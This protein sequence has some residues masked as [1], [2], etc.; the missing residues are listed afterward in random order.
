MTDSTGIVFTFAR[1]CNCLRASLLSL[2]PHLR[3]V[4]NETN[5]RVSK[6]SHYTYIAKIIAYSAA[7]KENGLEDK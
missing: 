2:K 6:M 3:R 1:L 7:S 4:S 5:L